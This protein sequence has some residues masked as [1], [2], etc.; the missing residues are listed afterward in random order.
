MDGW[1]PMRVLLRSDPKTIGMAE[2]LESRDDFH[3]RVASWGVQI[4][5]NVTASRNVTV[6]LIVNSLIDVWGVAN[7][8]GRLRGDDVVVSISDERIQR[9]A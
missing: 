9:P 3:A 6:A 1:V 2:F 5:R 7:E 8:R 4:D